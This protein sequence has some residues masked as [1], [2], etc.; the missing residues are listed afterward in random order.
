MSNH[1]FIK[2]DFGSRLEAAAQAPTQR[3]NTFPPPARYPA[4]PRY[5]TSSRYPPHR[6]QSTQEP[7]FPALTNS[8]PPCQ[9]CGKLSHQALDCYHRMDY[10]FQGR[11]PPTQLHA[12]AAH[13]TPA[14]EAQ[15]W[16]ADSAANAHITH[17][18]ENLHVQQPFQSPEGIAVGNGSTLAIANTGSAILSSPQSNFQL[19][20]VLH[21]P[22]A[23]ANLVSIQKFCLDNDCYFIITSSHFYIFDLQTKALLLERES[24][25]GMY[26]LKL[27]KKTYRGSKAFTAALGIKTTPLVWHFRL[28]HPSTEV[29]TRVVK[30]NNLPVSDL[31]FNKTVVCSSCQLGKA[32]KLPFH[33]SSRISSCPLQLIHTDLWTS[34]IPSMSGYKYYV[35]FVDDYSRYSWI[36]PLHTK[37]ETFAVFVQFKALVEKQFSTTIKQL[38]SDGGGEYTSHQFQSFLSQH[39]IAFRKSCPYTSPQNGL[40]ERKLRHILET[41]LTLL[42]HSHLSSKYWVDSF[43]TAIYI[44]NRLPTATI[45]NLSPYEKLYNQ[46]PDYKRMRVFGCLCY[47]LLRPYG[48]HKLEYRS[49]PCIFLG[50]QYA[51]YK[52]LDPVTNKA[53]LSRHVVFN[54]TSFPAQDHATS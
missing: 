16:Y 21:C 3:Y 10:A 46:P 32:T 12:M 42:A 47:P 25:N 50:Y 53:Y 43:L 33:A 2:L 45:Q 38:Q 15:E 35:I 24:E 5:P 37:S 9:I 40:A 1:V 11:H 51:G 22:K 4:P 8:R 48:H 6:T 26:P 28:G 14:Y 7:R 44:I 34:P 52:C 49:K 36:Y 18:L 19:N 39:G 41:G 30:A 54:E 17:D 31:N 23:A 13:T 20:H 29:V 27:C